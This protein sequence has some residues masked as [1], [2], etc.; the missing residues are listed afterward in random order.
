VNEGAARGR[1]D[2]RVA[3]TWVHGLPNDERIQPGV[4]IDAVVRPREKRGNP[5]GFRASKGGL[6]ERARKEE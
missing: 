1:G 6:I 5:R 2:A 3:A 4:K